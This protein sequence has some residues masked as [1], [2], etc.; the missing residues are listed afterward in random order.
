MVLQDLVVRKV[1]GVE[2]W[3]AEFFLVCLDILYIFLVY[4]VVIFDVLAL[5]S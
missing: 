2:K 1:G 4:D 5:L 3:M